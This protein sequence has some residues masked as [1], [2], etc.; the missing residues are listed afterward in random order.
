LKQNQRILIVDD[1][2]DTLTAGKLLL[3]RQFGTVITCSNPYDIP[4]LMK[5]H[6]FEA[7]LL[8]MNFS[9]GESSGE[10][11]F[12]WLKTILSINPDIVVIMMTAYGGVDIAVE[13]MKHGATDFI[14]KP[15]Q[16]E[17]VI[18]TLSSAIKLY[19]SRTETNQLKQNNQALIQATAIKNQ[20][21]LGSSAAMQRVHSIISK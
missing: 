18:A 8:D 11:G 9:I 6:S 5:K 21:I 16:N 14:S 13:A 19:K 2:P 10:Q 1:D 7:V 3:K 12:H 15:W 17:K 20:S 4:E